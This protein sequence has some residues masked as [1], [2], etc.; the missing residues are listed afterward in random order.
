MAESTQNNRFKRRLTPRT[1]PRTI[2]P[3]PSQLLPNQISHQ[4]GNFYGTG[5]DFLG[6][7]GTSESSSIETELG[8]A[9]TGG[10][11]QTL[12]VEAISN[13]QYPAQGYDPISQHRT[14]PTASNRFGTSTYGMTTNNEEWLLD[15]ALLRQPSGSSII[16]SDSILERETGRTYSRAGYIVPND[17]VCQKKPFIDHG[18]EC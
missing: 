1:E 9:W 14:I 16:E 6:R 11:D 15:D 13:Q 17:P 18:G 7:T 3:L 2:L 5:T 4:F 10:I 8:A 12:S